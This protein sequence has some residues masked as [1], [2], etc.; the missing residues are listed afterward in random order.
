MENKDMDDVLCTTIKIAY[1]LS[2]G[3]IN[4]FL[5]SVVD[6]NKESYKELLGDDITKHLS[7]I[8]FQ[9]RVVT[10]ACGLL[11][12]ELSQKDYKILGEKLKDLGQEIIVLS[13]RI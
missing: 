11:R 4:K 2:D 10:T 3:D 13:K 12:N 5:K 9:A 8:D 1:M 7:Q 6:A